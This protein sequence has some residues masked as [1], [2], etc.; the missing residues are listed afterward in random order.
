MWAY[1]RGGHRWIH[2]VGVLGRK[3]EEVT[4]RKVERFRRGKEQI[5][6]MPAVCQ[7]L[8]L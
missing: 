2:L 8:V 4:K 5:L 7:A 1:V 3:L 6:R